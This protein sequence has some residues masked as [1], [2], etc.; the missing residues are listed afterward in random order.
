MFIKQ[1]LRVLTL[2]TSLIDEIA[3][4]KILKTIFIKKTIE[5]SKQIQANF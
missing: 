3:I 1:Q 2:I 5:T 4:F